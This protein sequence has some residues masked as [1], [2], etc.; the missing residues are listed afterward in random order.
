MSFWLQAAEKS[1]ERIKADM[2]WKDFWAAPMQKGSIKNVRIFC[3]GTG[4][5][6][7]LFRTTVMLL[8]SSLFL[9]MFGGSFAGVVECRAAWHVGGPLTSLTCWMSNSLLSWWPRRHEK[10]I[11]LYRIRNL[12]TRFLELQEVF[13]SYRTSPHFKIFKNPLWAQRLTLWKDDPSQSILC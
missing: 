7:V 8:L 6:K 5:R 12:L 13:S 11:S 3:I 10:I 4:K 9:A 2:E 1:L